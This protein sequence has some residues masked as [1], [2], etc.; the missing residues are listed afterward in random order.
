MFRSLISFLRSRVRL[1]RFELGGAFGDVGTDLPLLAGMILVSEFDAASVLVVF[2]A[3]QLAAGLVYGIPMAV[4]PL[5]AVAA[6]VIAQNIAAPV[7][8][9]AGLSMGMVM[10]ALAVTGML[11]KFARLIPKAVVRG[12][13]LG[14]GGNLAILAM[15]QYIPA[16]GVKG[17]YLAAATC[18]IIVL[19]RRNSRFP[20][21]LVAMGLGVV[22]VLFFCA[23]GE[24]ADHGHA[25]RASA[26]A[27]SSGVIGSGRFS[28]SGAC[29]N[30][31]VAGQF[32]AGH[33]ATGVRLLSGKEYHGREDWPDLWDHEHRCTVSGRRTGLSWLRRAGW[34]LYF[35]RAHGRI[36]CHSRFAIDDWRAVVWGWFCAI[37]P[38][39]PVVRFG[40]ESYF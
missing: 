34:A 9:G 29:A 22:Y 8:F 27:G 39:L 12:I 6:L 25:F 26:V 15:C 13:Q 38:Y 23:E 19:L 33:R 24:Q 35:W 1:D 30:P 5:K 40:H 31:A 4:Q 20:A 17:L 10:L 18:A 16:D 14:L 28:G 11:E 32:G 3:M 21:S 37:S 36:G 7:V 2:G